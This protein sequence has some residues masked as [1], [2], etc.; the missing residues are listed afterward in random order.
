MDVDNTKK[1]PIN[2]IKVPP[3]P[4]SDLAAMGI[5]RYD[6][7]IGTLPIFQWTYRDFADTTT[8]SA[9]VHELW[10]DGVMMAVPDQLSMTGHIAARTECIN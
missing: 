2:P 4:G 1:H 3:I 9:H 8:N 7:E 6:Q 5:D 10:I